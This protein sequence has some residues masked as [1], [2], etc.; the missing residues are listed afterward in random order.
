[1]RLKAT[2]RGTVTYEIGGKQYVA[3]RNT[4]RRTYGR[5]GGAAILVFAL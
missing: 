3:V 4:S 1:M 5:N 2:G